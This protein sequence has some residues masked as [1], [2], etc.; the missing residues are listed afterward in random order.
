MSNLKI[1]DKIYQQN[2][3]KITGTYTVQRVTKTLAICE[4][5]AKF[6]IEYNSPNWINS[7]GNIDKWNTNSFSLETPELKEMLYRQISI[8][9]IRGKKFE[10]MTTEQIRAIMAII[11]KPKEEEK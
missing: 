10:E 11:K 6:R 8:M 1:G 9:E 2:Y 7:A 4:G 5:D 3:G